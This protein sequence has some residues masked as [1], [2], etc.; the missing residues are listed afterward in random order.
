MNRLILIGIFWSLAISIGRAQEGAEPKEESQTPTLDIEQ[1]S[2][3]PLSEPTPANGQISPFRPRKS[4]P[5]LRVADPK[6]IVIHPGVDALESEVA[7]R[8]M[9]DLEKTGIAKINKAE[10]SPMSGAP[11][12]MQVFMRDDEPFEKIKQFIVDLRASGVERMVLEFG[13][14]HPEG[15]GDINNGLVFRAT[16]GYSQ[17]ELQGLEKVVQQAAERCG[18]VLYFA[19]AH[20]LPSGPS[21][22]GP[23]DQP[24]DTDYA[25][26]FRPKIPQLR[27][28]YEAA[29][30]H[31]HDLAESLRQT[32]DPAK[33]S[34]LRTAVQRAFTLRQSLLRA[35]LQEMQ[36]RLEKT[37]QSLDMRDRI[38]DQIVERRVEDLLNPQL[39]WEDSALPPT[40]DSSP[41]I[42][43]GGRYNADGDSSAGRTGFS[44]IKLLIPQKQFLPA[45]GTTALGVT[46]DDLDLFKILNMEPVPA[47]AVEHFPDWLK[48]LNGKTVRIRGFMYPTF[49]A[50]SLKQF[51]LA[52]HNDICC[53]VRSPR[54]YDVIGVSL[55]DGVTTDYLDGRPFDVEGTFHIE[56]KADENRLV[57]LY[58]ISDARILEV[59]RRVEYLLNPQLEWE[60]G[61][62][63]E[64]KTQSELKSPGQAES[65]VT[66]DSGVV[67]ELEGDWHLV[68]IKDK[69]GDPV[70]VQPMN[71]SF[72]NDR[73]TLSY[74]GYQNERRVEVYP[75][76]KEIRYFADGDDAFTRDQYLMDSDQ[77]TIYTENRRNVY[78]RGHVALPKSIAKATDEQKTRWRSG[79]VDIIAHDAKVPPSDH[80]RVGYGVIL[81]PQMLIVAQLKLTEGDWS[82][83]A[84]FDD[85]SIVPIKI[86]EE[87]PQGWATFQ[88]EKAIEVNH[89]FQLSATA[90]GQHD[91]VNFWGRS[92]IISEQPI[93]ELFTTTVT[94]LD[95]KSPAMGSTVWQL[96]SHDRLEG[97]LP[98]LDANGDVLAIGLIG[99]GDLFLA[100][101]V[102]QLKTMFPKSFGPA[103]PM[104]E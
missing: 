83:F 14:L 20:V 26:G 4:E 39:K 61:L 16:K 18:L 51:T 38:A 60:G 87:G 70:D 35:E 47:N 79:I 33:K 29:N 25:A 45:P 23:G 37:Q 49:E 54:I 82:F 32:P 59:D 42:G 7:M 72:R 80:K 77:L 8:F 58:S 76:Q 78:H 19:G 31:A 74:Q 85:G 90:V 73:Y 10:I 69:A 92:A 86:V 66:D 2:P 28:D 88:P 41:E 67:T 57:R 22:I 17:D 94:A 56:P 71:L 34:E 97:S 43:T 44:N 30:K 81:S 5:I 27:T 3:L 52:R 13:G 24:A 63:G 36:A 104:A 62:D 102:S 98:I 50:H 95:R 68:S 101:P 64:R 91:E 96:R 40:K 75:D 12:L 9:A 1:S 11:I 65:S 6:R 53:F 48:E 84:R 103:A 100:V 21:F 89:H 93:S 15:N 55:I 99:T 46:Y